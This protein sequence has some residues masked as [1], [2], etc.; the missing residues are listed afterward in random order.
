MISVASTD[1]TYRGRFAPTPSGPLHLGSLVTAL[2]SYLQARSRGG[3]WLLR[4]DDLDE[5][6]CPP[7]MDAEILRQ[8]EAHGLEWDE[9]PRH[10]SRHVAE[11]EAA[12]A[13]LRER[14]R[15]YWCGCTRAV[16][17]AT[18]LPGPDGPVY[19]GTCRNLGLE[20]GSARMRLEAKRVVLDDP[21]QGH[22]S[23]EPA[24]I[25]DFVVR[26]ADGTIAYQ[27][28]CVVDEQAQRIT[29]VVRGA[30]LL[31]STF[32]QLCLH[33]T[34]A[35]RPPAYR[36]LPVVVDAAGRK[37]SKQNHAPP[38]GAREASTN[39][40]ACL[41]L[42]QQAPPAALRGAAV[43]ETRAWAVAHWN[44]ATVPR[45]AQIEGG[46]AYNALQQKAPSAP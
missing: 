24:A 13:A 37:L 22:P 38:I 32:Q 1:T 3:S 14:A 41:A 9:A 20:H 5:P 43:E 18:A 21:W 6:R 33:E 25:G 8:L 26:R 15:L 16:L 30:D 34:L 23:R 11:Y 4:I 29:E 27:L 46:I 42:L 10:Q 31:G 19:P 7:G 12:F 36:H 28:A 40:W 45:A 17:K 44:A 39:L 35:L 2:A